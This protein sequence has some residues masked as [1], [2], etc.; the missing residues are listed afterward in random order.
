M[1]YEVITGFDM[2]MFFQGVYGNEIYNAV[3]IR[4]EGKG[5]EATLS[6]AM[7]N[8]WSASNPNGTIPNPYGNSNN[9]ATSSRFVEDGA[10]LRMKN[11][12]LGYTLPADIT[13]KVSIDRCR[14]YVTASNL[15]TFTKYTVV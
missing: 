14:F 13:K 1:L 15:L 3:R 10:Y 9:Y 12:Q 7:R 8:V 11:I 2:Q 5:T 4:T 6:T